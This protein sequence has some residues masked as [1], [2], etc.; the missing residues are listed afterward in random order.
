MAESQSAYAYTHQNLRNGSTPTVNTSH[1]D[2]T[3]T[4][5]PAMQS[6]STPDCPPSLSSLLHKP[7]RILIDDR[8]TFIGVFMCTDPQ[9]NVILSE[10]EEFQAPPRTPEEVALRQN[11]DMYYP[12]SQRL[13]H[14]GPGW[15][16]WMGNGGEEGRGDGVGRV[17]GLVL[18]PGDKIVKMELLEASG[19]SYSG[20]WDLE[21]NAEARIKQEDRSGM[22]F[23]RRMEMDGVI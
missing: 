20:S 5:T 8:R 7:L 13:P 1:P 10:A 15:G 3:S 18:I 19:E 23:D 14:D 9:A 22:D 2:S 6:T 12:K 21:G 16:M 11:R 4:P 17:M